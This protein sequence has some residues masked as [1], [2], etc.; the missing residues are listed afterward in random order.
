MTEKNIE[1]KNEKKKVVKINA[2]YPLPN[3]KISLKSQIDLIKAYVVVSNSGREPVNYN[4]FKSLVDIHPT[5]I[6]GNNEFF[7]SIGLIKEVEGKRGYYLPNEQAIKL[8]NAL[9]WNKQ[10]EVK[11]I[12]QELLSVTWF[13]NTTKQLLDYKGSA[14]RDDLLNKLGHELK[15]ILKDIQHH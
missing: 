1:S 6:S 9:K 13:W 15:L 11:S 3:A 5:I 10:E 4:S 14:S 8:S 7:V 12:L 2:K